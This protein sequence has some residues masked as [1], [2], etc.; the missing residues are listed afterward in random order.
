MKTPSWERNPLIWCDEEDSS[1]IRYLSSK[2]ITKTLKEHRE[3]QSVKMTKEFLGRPSQNM[4]RSWGE[5]DVEERGGGRR[6]QSE[7][8][9]KR[10]RRPQKLHRLEEVRGRNVDYM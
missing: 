6:R 9:I 3:A 5:G 10:R 4:S 8:E 2:T 7:G 1:S